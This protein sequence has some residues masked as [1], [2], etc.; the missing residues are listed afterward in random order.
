MH[1]IKKQFKWTKKS[2]INCKQEYGL[3]TNILSSKSKWP[4]IGYNSVFLIIW[5]NHF[6]SLMSCIAHINLWL[7]FLIHLK[8]NE[9]KKFNHP[10]CYETETK[11]YIWNDTSYI[12]EHQNLDNSSS[13]LV[14]WTLLQG[15]TTKGPKCT[16]YGT[17]CVHDA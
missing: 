17:N 14:S 10:S 2:E 4:G 16:N 11:T 6:N 1:F 5:N 12:E 15:A 9:S 13:I 8:K 7:N 3:I